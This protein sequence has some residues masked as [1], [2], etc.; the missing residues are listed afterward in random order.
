MYIFSIWVQS[1]GMKIEKFTF[2]VI[3]QLND[4]FFDGIFSYI[5]L[6][7]WRNSDTCVHYVGS[8]LRKNEF[9]VKLIYYNYKTHLLGNYNVDPSSYYLSQFV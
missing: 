6:K 3:F 9:K 5:L 8:T 1:Y 2:G 4:D 7:S